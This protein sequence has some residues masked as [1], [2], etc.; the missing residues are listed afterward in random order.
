MPRHPGISRAGDRQPCPKGCAFSRSLHTHHDSLLTVDNDPH[1]LLELMELAVTWHELD[2]SGTQVI[3]PSQWLDFLD[4]HQWHD[5][6]LAERIF[7]LATDIARHPTRHPQHETASSPSIL[8][9][10]PAHVS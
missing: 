7:S 4:C 1:S 5:P 6:D 2:Y 8:R 10:A 9:L 3:P